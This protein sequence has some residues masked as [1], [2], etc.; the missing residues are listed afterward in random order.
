MIILQLDTSEGR[1]ARKQEEI[2]SFLGVSR[3][4]VNN[5]RRSFLEK[6]D[7]EVFLKRKKREKPPVEP[8]I[9][10]EVEAHIVALETVV[11]NV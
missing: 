4:L 10:G 1:K 7:M 11:Q 5:A 3:Q 6:R 8:K 2:A 9:T